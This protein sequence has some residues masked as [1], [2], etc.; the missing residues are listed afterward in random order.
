MKYKMA[1]LIWI[2]VWRLKTA[3]YSFSSLLV[4]LC[5]MPTMRSVANDKLFN[6]SLLG[7]FNYATRNVTPSL[8]GLVSVKLK[9]NFR[10]ES[11]YKCDMF[12]ESDQTELLKVSNRVLYHTIPVGLSYS[13]KNFDF[14]LGPLFHITGFANMNVERVYE[15]FNGSEGLTYLDDLMITDR[16]R[17]MFC[18]LFCNV[19]YN[20]DDYYGLGVTYGYGITNRFANVLFKT[21]L[22][23]VGFTFYLRMNDK[24]LR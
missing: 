24:L 14:V 22:H 7:A 23:Y 13:L 17:K 4:F 19:R 18:S 1:K 12:I 2:N 6:Y 21:P 16:Y 9:G 20:F 3:M 5:C 11:G 15:K 8:G 10:V